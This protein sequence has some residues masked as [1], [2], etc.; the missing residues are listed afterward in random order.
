MP[1]E[2]RRLTF[3]GTEL[4]Q[5]IQD[6]PERPVRTQPSGDITAITPVQ[7][8]DDHF[9]D[10]MFFDMSKQ[11]EK[12]VRIPEEVALTA[13]IDLCVAGKIP[14]PRE[15]QKMLRLVEQRLCLD[16]FMGEAAPPA[17]AE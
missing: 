6:S 4:K 14:L 2:F 9:Y 10:V 11:K 16:I 1:N 8:R 5:A 17:A 12:K 15:S 7:E 3:H 13:L